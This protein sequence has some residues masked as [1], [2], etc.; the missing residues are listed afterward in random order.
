[1]PGRSPGPWQGLAGRGHDPSD[2]PGRDRQIRVALLDQGFGE[3]DRVEPRELGRGKLDESGPDGR[4]GLVDR[5]PTA[6]AVDQCGGS[7]D[8]IANEQTADMARRQPQHARRIVGR[9]LTGEDMG[10]D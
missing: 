5:C 7:V 8:P 1:M 9:Q 6:V 4:V 2:G 10:E 3:V